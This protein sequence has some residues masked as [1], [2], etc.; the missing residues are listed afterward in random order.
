M[1][2]EAGTGTVRLGRRRRESED[3]SAR[4]GQWGLNQ[5]GSVEADQGLKD[6]DPGIFL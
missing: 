1:T 5:A 4:C 2:K 3:A 6:K